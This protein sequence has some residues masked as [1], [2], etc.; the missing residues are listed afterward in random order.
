MAPVPA[1]IVCQ[2]QDAEEQLLAR[3]L[4]ILSA[5]WIAFQDFTLTRIIFARRVLSW[6]VVAPWW[7]VATK[8]IFDVTLAV[9]DGTWTNWL[10]NAKLV[11][12]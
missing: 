7:F 3:I 12:R 8:R 10:I 4:E 11:L 5:R 6:L 2:Y 9:R 1:K